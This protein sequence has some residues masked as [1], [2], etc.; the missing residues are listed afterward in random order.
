MTTTTAQPLTFKRVP[1]STATR[2]GESYYT[3]KTPTRVYDVERTADGKQWVLGISQAVAV[4]DLII[5]DPEA[6]PLAR[7]YFDTMALARAAAKAYHDLGDNYRPCDHG[8]RDRY[9]EAVKRAY[10]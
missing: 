4:A 2:Q 7:G 10:A 6:S 9:T 8:H 1:F 5:R 3:A